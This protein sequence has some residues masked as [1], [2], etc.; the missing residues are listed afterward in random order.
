MNHRHA[1]V[2]FLAFS[3]TFAT[4]TQGAL[5][6]DFLWRIK[7]PTATVYLL[8]SVHLLRTTDYPLPPSFDAAYNAA[9]QIV[10]EAD[11]DEASSANFSSYVISKASYPSGQTI[12]SSLSAV[13][14]QK[15]QQFAR[16]HGLAIN[17]FDPFRPWF[18]S[19]LIFVYFAQDAGLQSS[20]GVDR[21]YLDATKS[22]GK[23]RLFLETPAFQIDTLAGIPESEYVASLPTSIDS[24]SQA[25]IT[26]VSRWKGGD[27]EGLAQLTE[28][29]R[30]KSPETYRRLILDRNMN[31]VPQIENFLKQ[32]K[33]TLVIVGA[34]HLVGSD[35]VV[36]RLMSRNHNVLQLPGTPPSVGGLAL[37]Y[38]PVRGE[39]IKFTESSGTLNLVEQ[40]SFSMTAP[41]N[42]DGPFAAQWWKDGQPMPGATN[43]IYTKDALRVSDSG[44]YQVSVQSEFGR[45][46]SGSF[47]LMVVA[48][49]PA[50]LS[51]ER[52]QSLVS[53]TLRGTTNAHYRLEF[54]EQLPAGPWTPLT[55]LTLFTN[56]AR[57]WEENNSNMRF[58]RA[59]ATSL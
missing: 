52:F 37:D 56:Q 22:G 23:T 33:T 27:V 55:G 29:S 34:A 57:I 31:F 17:F 5:A 58:Y 1:A 20:L 30:T 18:A 48:P 44:W 16:A 19:I 50:Q 2:R 43:M 54:A 46:T 14:Y 4:L 32:T 39:Q 3:L 51:I 8:G 7:S 26:V 24:G 40:T 25:V 47:R 36:A 28:A 49:A 12:R 42:G 15:L 45:V 9:Q 10:F 21:H 41:V 59:I 35:G 38:A 6:K 53:I 13:T 11:L